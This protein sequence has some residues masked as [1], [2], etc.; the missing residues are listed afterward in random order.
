M[1]KLLAADCEDLETVAAL[2]QDSLVRACD[3]HYD[4]RRRALT[5]LVNRYRWEEKEPQRGHA[6][7]RLTGVL[8]A[9][10]R[11][12]PTTKAAV[13][14][15]LHI[16]CDDDVVEMFFAGGTAVRCRIETIDLLLE[17]VGEPWPVSGPPSHDDDDDPDEDPDDE[18]DERE[19]SAAD[20]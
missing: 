6:I 11:S 5:L 9:Q 2:L 8:K 3:T 18:P 16:E 12:W 4:S 10:H 1:V 7:V 14:E 13:L 19:R 17:D 15:L 20:A